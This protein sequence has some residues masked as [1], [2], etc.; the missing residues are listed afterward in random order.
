MKTYYFTELSESA[1]KKHNLSLLIAERLKTNVLPLF[2]KNGNRVK[3]FFGKLFVYSGGVWVLDEISHNVIDN[4]HSGTSK[5][6][7]PHPVSK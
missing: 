1:K 5:L 2:D 3:Q 7:H 4:K 6:Y